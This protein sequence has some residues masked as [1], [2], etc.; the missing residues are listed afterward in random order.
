MEPN[1]DVGFS[2]PP[3][4]ALIIKGRV[5]LQAPYAQNGT[6]QRSEWNTCDQTHQAPRAPSQ[7][8]FRRSGDARGRRAETESGE[9]IGTQRT[10]DAEGAPGIRPRLSRCVQTHERSCSQPERSRMGHASAQDLAARRWGNCPRPNRSFLRRF[11]RKSAA[12]ASV[13]ALT[14]LVDSEVTSDALRIPK[15][16]TATDAAARTATAVSE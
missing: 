15:K 16:A 5:V 14:S 3:R 2:G 4:D 6:P 7:R 9:A 8:F 1:T 10:R 12:P 11:T 13:S